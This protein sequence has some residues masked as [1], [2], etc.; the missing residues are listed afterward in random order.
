[1]IDIENILYRNQDKLLESID[2]VL[3]YTTKKVNEIKAE[4]PSNSDYYEGYV[5]GLE[6]ARKIIFEYKQ[7]T[8][9][10]EEQK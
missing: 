3:W 10:D 2:N 5:M 6:R 8:E 9:I 4:R 7:K 1:M